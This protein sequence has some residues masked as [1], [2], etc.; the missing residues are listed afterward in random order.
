MKRWLH[1]AILC[2]LPILAAAQEDPAKPAV[3]IADQV[4]VTPDR[5]LVAQGNV[6]VYQG[7]IRMDAPSVRFDQD[8][9]A[10]NIEGPIVISQG[11]ETIILAD[12]GELDRELRNGLLQGARLILAQHLQLAAH[13]V[14]RVDG[15]YNQLSKASV[16]SCRVCEDG[17]APLWQ[18]RAQRVV[19]DQEEQQ[20]YF[21]HAQ[22]RILDVPVFYLPRLRMPGPGLDRATG[23]LVPS[24]RTTSLLGTGFKFP[25]FITLGDS[26]D[27]TITPYL[28]SA[29]RTV[30]LR[31]RQAFT[32][33]R[34]EFNAA[35]TRDDQRPG[36]TRGYL[37]GRGY[38]DLA[39]DY[40]LNFDIETV[41]DAAYFPD[42][43]YLTKDRLTSQITIRRVRR[44]QFVRT[45]LYNFESLRDGDINDNLPNLVFDSEYEQRLF[46]AAL[47]GE[48]RLNLQT[49]AHRRASDLDT[50]GS[51]ADLI[52]DG[53]DVARLH[54]E[55]QW[56]RRL[57]FRTGVVTDLQARLSFNVFDITQDATF[58]QN[59]TELLGQMAVAFRYP[60]I[61]RGSNGVV[62]ILEPVAQLAWTGGNR[63][64]VPN[65]ESTGVEFDEGNLLSLSRFPSPDRRERGQVVALGVNWARMNPNGWDTH[66]TLGQLYR[67]ESDADFST[68]SGLTGTTS[69]FLLAGQVKMPGGLSLT[70]RSLFDENLDFAKAEVRGDYGFG[71]GNVSG[72]YVWLDSDSQEDRADPLSEIFLAGGYDIN[73]HWRLNADWR[74]NVVD[75]R[76]ATA[77]LG[78]SYN[79]ECVAV[80][81]SV[82][83]RYS[84]STSVEPTTNFGFNVALRGF[85]GTSG[86]E[87]YTRSCQR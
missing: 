42:Y 86:A 6:E 29:T 70:G 67:Q 60:M 27:L 19:H 54:A 30:E 81:L 82:S 53:R 49:H 78:L 47:G 44:D 1:I 56:L 51:D 11:P 22:F 61:R 34:I 69:H 2:L 39:R 36:E 59:Q 84:S 23:F 10:L 26:R 9:G 50:D 7:D 66:L 72:S 58:D 37:T 80:D 41:S 31:C 62:Q 46:P 76:A 33:G 68:S 13:Q 32:R 4:F 48:I 3:L 74:F 24:V 8:T 73:K 12:A 17:R 45:S 28:S 83:R 75:D 79:N 40:K 35:A 85:A 5:I 65:E 16:T 63:L 18:I 55:A 64:S 52:V 71:R 14:D 25:Y 87:K 38:F 20:L 57:T 21:D 15:R 43:S 77:G